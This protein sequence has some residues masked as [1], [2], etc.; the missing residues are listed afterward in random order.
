MIN[1]LLRKVGLLLN[2]LKKGD[3]LLGDCSDFGLNTQLEQVRHDLRDISGDITHTH[4]VG[5]DTYRL[6]ILITAMPSYYV[7]KAEVLTRTIEDDQFV[8]KKR[9]ID[10]R[11]NKQKIH[12]MLLAGKIGKLG[13]A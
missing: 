1:K 10:R 12:D 9:Y 4:W 13:I 7:L 5:S 3:I 11:I 6:T 8:W 2:P